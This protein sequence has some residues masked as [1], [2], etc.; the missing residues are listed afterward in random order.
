MPEEYS[1]ELEF[2]D[3]AAVIDGIGGDVDVL[4]HSHGAVCA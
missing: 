2:D 3:V 4:G 1:I